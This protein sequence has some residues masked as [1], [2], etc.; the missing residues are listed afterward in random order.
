MLERLAKEESFC[1]NEKDLQDNLSPQKYTG[2]CAA[3]VDAFLK[4]V[5]PLISEAVT[6]SADIEI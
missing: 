6:S 2:R 1:L 4:K 3:Q 5:R